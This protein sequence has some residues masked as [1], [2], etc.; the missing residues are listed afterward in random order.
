MVSKQART[1]LKKWTKACDKRLNRLISY[2]H[3][4]IEYK[5]YCHVGNTA[6]QCRF[7]LFQDSDC[8]RDLEDSKSTSGGTLCVLGSHTFV[9]ISWMCKKQTSVSHSSTESEIISLDTGLRLD[10]IPA[11][12]LWDLIVSVFGNISHVLDRTEQPVNGKNKSHNKIDV[13]HDIDSVPSNVQSP[14]REALLYVFEDNEAVIKMIMK[15][16]SPTM[17]HVSRTHRVALDWLFDRINLDPKIQIKYIDTKNQLADI[18]TKGNFT[19][20]EWNHLLTLFKISHFSSA[21]CIAAM[22][23]RAQQESGEGRV[24]AKSRPMMNLIARTP[25]FV[26]SSA[27]SNP[28]RTWYGYQDPGKSVAN[29]DRSGKLRNRHH[30][31]IQKRI[32]VN[33]GL[34]KSGKVELRSTIDQGN[35]K[36]ILGIHCKKVDPHREEY[37]LG[38][39]AHSARNEETIHDRTGQPVSENLQGEAHFENF[40]IGSEITEFVNKV[41]NQVR[42]RQKRMSSIAEDCTEHSIIWGMFMATTL[43]AATF[44]GKNFSTMQN[45]VKNQE[46]LTLKQMFDVTAQMVHNEEEIYCLDKI[47]YQK[48][49]WTKLSLINDPVIINLQSTKVYVF[50]DSVLCL[51]KVLQHPECS[52]AWKNRVAGVRAE[53]SYRDYETV[54]GESTEFEWNIFPGFT[55]L[56]L[57]DKISNLLSSLG[58]TPETFT[59]RILFLS[60]FNHISCDRYDNKNECLKNADFV[61]TFAKRFGIGQWFFI[62]P[63]SE[64]KWYPSENSPQGAWDHVA[65]EMLLKFAESGHPIFRSTTPLSRGQLK[66]KRKGKVSIHFTAD[67]DTVDTIYRI[68][69]SVNQLS[70]YGAVAAICDEYEGHQDSTG[71]PVILVGQSIVL[72]EIKTEGPAHDEE[73]KDDPIF[74]QQYFQQVES[75]SPENRLSKFCKEAGFMCVVEVGQYFVTRNAGEFQHTVACREYTLPR[76]DKASQPK[77]WIRG[78]M[79]IGLVLE[80]TTSFQ[81]FK[82]GIEIRIESVNKDN[83]HSWV[84]ISYGTVKYVNDYI[85][86]DTE[87]LADPQEEEDVPTSSGVVAARS[88]AKAKPQPRESTG[89]TTIPLSERI[90]ID[91]EP[92]Q[93]DLESYNLSKKVVNLLRHNQK[94][95]R[96]EDGAIQFY[97]IKFHL[98]DHHPQIQNWSDDPNEDISIALIIWDQLFI[99]VLFKDILGAIS[100]ILHY[101][102]T[103]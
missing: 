99:S 93:Q 79:R 48:N 40:I 55:S 28:G 67:Q 51:G 44:M 98:R 45:V 90:W 56:Q 36:K 7:G 13:V 84:R 6:K 65:E 34:L 101:R 8:A 37:L 9:P 41:R 20:D 69:L 66:S 85:K 24:T 29:D 27:S 75:L 68:I 102:T 16:R 62:G 43:N 12:E 87:N 26:S 25:S 58:Q 1:R 38:R 10:G 54:S 33:L 92:S 80:V 89:A 74:L 88:K 11:L 60:M 57:C 100:L 42:I 30:Q 52:E 64:K 4:T 77:G 59:G 95:H 35:L 91:I 94:L 72:G 50:S 96:E 18:L 63:G 22:A 14:N 46:S 61:K 31:I 97:K 103:C 39:T 17:R 83:S 47:V 76:D 73:P 81:H 23:K 53:R 49:S 2:I 15:G 3:H 21:A 86:D 32:V 78:N 82:Y 70:V 71:Q 19:R 5:Q